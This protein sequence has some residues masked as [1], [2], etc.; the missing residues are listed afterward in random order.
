MTMLHV[1]LVVVMC[2][3]L[4]DDHN[5]HVHFKNLKELFHY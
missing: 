2:L 1:P 3:G 5:D 4:L